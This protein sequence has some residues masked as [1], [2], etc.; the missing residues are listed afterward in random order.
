VTTNG[1]DRKQLADRLA[2]AENE[3][4]EAEYQ[5]HLQQAAIDTLSGGSWDI[6]YARVELQRFLHD[7]AM[8]TAHRNCLRAELVR[9]DRNALAA[10]WSATAA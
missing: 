7:H 10:A 4:L 9:L 3:V 1:I 5:V 2:R 8:R 6:V